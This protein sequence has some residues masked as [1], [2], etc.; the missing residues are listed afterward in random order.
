MDL[1]AG[2]VDRDR[3]DFVEKDKK[4]TIE[5]RI[6]AI[7]TGRA[8]QT[9][10]AP[11]EKQRHGDESKTELAAAAP[12]TSK[13]FDSATNPV[14]QIMQRGDLS[15]KGKLE[16]VVDFLDATDENFLA[17]QKN[18]AAFEAYFTSEQSKRTEVS[19]Q[20]IE[21]L[22]GELAGTTNATVKH[23]LRDFDAVNIGAGK[24]KQLLMVMERA[25]VDGKT[26]E[27]LTAAYRGNEALLTQIVDLKRSLATQVS[28]QTQTAQQLAEMQ[29]EK[30]SN[31]ASALSNLFGLFGKRESIS[32]ALYYSAY[33]LKDIQGKI[34][35]LQQTIDAR[36]AQ[37]HTD[38][39]NGDLTILRTVDATEGGLTDQ[40]LQTANDSLALLKGMRLSI[41][42]LLAANARSRAACTD[43]SKTL[44]TMSG[45]ETILKGALEVVA[46]DARHHAEALHGDID[47]LTQEKTSAGVDTVQ[48]TLLTVQIDKATQA[49]ELALDYERVVQ[50]KVVAF[51]M[52]GSANVQ[53]GARAQQFATLIDSQH[54]VLSNLQQQALPVTAS[55]LEMGLQQAV[56][57]RDGLL[58]AGVRDA[59]RKAQEIFGS[60]LQGATDAQTRLGIENLN[61]MRAA[62]AALGNA[63]SIISHRTDKA[64][65]HGLESLDLLE[66][67]ADQAA[68]VRTAMADFQN[69]DN[70]LTPPDAGPASA[71]PSTGA[72]PPDV[73]PEVPAGSAPATPAGAASEV[74]AGPA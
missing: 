61:Q 4:M 38:L 20:N 69:V 39:E 68:K 53:A 51:Q 71:A 43:I 36:E 32:Q 58:A 34:H 28:R 45:G 8:T 18:F 14:S 3:A 1:H 50:T 33:D 9:Q 23:I 40:I 19:E 57:L 5:E 31:D 66:Q 37:R 25:R 2:R 48:S 42:S 65:E 30:T 47:R 24:I 46:L 16:A 22:M 54:E 49:D 35:S 70:A 26:V 6:A 63:Q 12:V 62:I 10:A 41:E 15:D 11:V 67:M 59:T 60:S 64:I 52:L 73:A 13:A 72:T 56:T 17:T 74:P 44:N 21:R 27:V 55:A 29:D 7:R